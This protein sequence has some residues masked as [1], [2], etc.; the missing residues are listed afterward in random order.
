MLADFLEPFWE[1]LFDKMGTGGLLVAGSV[2]FLLILLVVL[3]IAG[4]VAVIRKSVA[5]AKK[6]KQEK[7]A[8][9]AMD[10]WQDG[11]YGEAMEHYFKLEKMRPL[12]SEEKYDMA[13]ICADGAQEGWPYEDK[14]HDEDY[15]LKQAEKEGSVEAMQY[16]AHKELIHANS[17]LEAAK[18]VRRLHIVQQKG[19]SDAQKIMDNYKARMVEAKI[20]PRMIKLVM[21]D[22]EGMTIFA[23]AL[24][25][26]GSMDAEAMGWLLLAADYGYAEA[27]YQA[28]CRLID[29]DGVKQDVKEGVRLLKEAAGKKH[30]LACAMLG[31]VYAGGIV[32]NKPNLYTARDWFEKSL[33][34]KENAAVMYE[35][36]MLYDRMFEERAKQLNMDPNAVAT[37][38]YCGEYYRKKMKWLRKAEKLGNQDAKKALDEFYSG[39]ENGDLLRKLGDL[40]EDKE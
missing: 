40:L 23:Q 26:K 39:M 38:R 27:Q 9:R 36:G 11:E 30:A 32:D 22:A 28:G 3:L 15:W 10:L 20:D 25:D 21:G 12:T 24:F 29:G 31:V 35:L 4:V 7:L 17:T 8:Q 13:L 14:R 6:R 5:A 34:I 16:A 18:A 2:P 33:E 19:S 37:D 1:W